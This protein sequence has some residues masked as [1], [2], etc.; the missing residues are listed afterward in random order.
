MR[1]ILF[2]GKR[3]DNGEWVYGSLIKTGDY[4]CILPDDDGTSW[5]YPYLDG[6]LGTID[7]K[8]IPVDPETVGQFINEWD[9]NGRKL[10]EGD[11][12]KVGGKWIKAGE[13]YTALIIADNSC[14]IDLD[15]FGRCRPQ[16]TVQVEV[17]GNIY[18]NQELL[19]DKQKRWLKNYYFP[20]YEGEPFGKW[21]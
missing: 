14:L 1:K 5:D 20:D 10:F 4:C 17:V 2:R 3:I 19:S 16:D 12:V 13:E 7:G 18:D 8:A 9:R 15:G 6:E 11:L 21:S